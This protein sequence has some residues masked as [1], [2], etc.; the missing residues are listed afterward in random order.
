M[1]PAVD[2]ISRQMGIISSF[3]PNVA[4][5]ARCQAPE[6]FEV[7][8]Q[9]K[10]HLKPNYL[11]AKIQLHSGLN[12]DAWSIALAKY[13]DTELCRYLRYG[14][15]LGYHKSSPPV[16]LED[17]HQSATQHL[18]DVRAFIK[19][20]LSFGALV[21]PFDTQP[22]TPW[23][24]V[25]PAMTRPKMDL[26]ER[27]VIVDMSFP[28]VDGVNDGI[29]TC[30]YYG[31]NITYTLP[32]IKNLISRLQV[33]GKGALVWKADLARA[34]R[35]LRVN[36]LDAP[37]LG[38]KVDGKYY[39]DACPPFGCRSSS[40]ACQRLSNA[41]TYIFRSRGFMAL[42]Y[43]DD[44]AGCESTPESSFNAFHNFIALAKQLGLE[45]AAHKCVQPTTNIEWLG[46][47]FNTE[48]MTVS[49]PSNKLA[50]VLKE[51][52]IWLG[53]KTASKKMI[54]SL[55]GRLLYIT[56]CIPP[57]R[58]FLSRILATLSGM[59]D[60]K[61][62]T[63]S[64]SF[65]LDVVW[66]AR[67]ARQAN[68]VFYYQPDR[69]HIEIECDSSLYGGGGVALQYCYSWVYPIHHTDKYHLIHHL[70]A[71]NLLVAYR[72]LANK[73][74]RQGAAI[75]IATDNEGSSFA[76][77]TGGTKDPVFASCSR[78][79]WLDAISNNHI[80]LVRHKSGSLIPLSDALSRQS[81]D[82]QKATY[83]REEIK[84][85]N[86]NIIPPVLNGYAFFDDMI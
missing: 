24:R 56:N 43:L 13:H 38:L 86:L 36:P 19:K 42:A 49:V 65:K 77:Q 34:Y 1:A 28:P 35:Q 82:S 55:A 12:F 70:E 23:L 39:L 84:W 57:A 21:G 40:A 52:E 67:F 37:L 60:G 58:R 46:Y 16:T 64:T 5:K 51:C 8:D 53:R 30:D 25:S 61:W 33:C 27:R 48:T 62:I 31:K 69:P 9:I 22:F 17:N 50:E 4:P 63:L 29:D 2:P 75:I 6:F 3:W 41:V 66:F 74:Y 79:L 59:V 10:S 32:T 71:L 68:G 54:Q 18:D 26:K 72:T 44:Y 45:L 73:I 7:Y 20:E 80:V 15:P 47:Q 14:W 11:S 85:R 78:Q 76:L 83:A 81:R